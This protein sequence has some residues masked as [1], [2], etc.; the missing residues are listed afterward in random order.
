MQKPKY[1]YMGG[2]LRPWEEATLHVA[3]E[4]A[5]RSA[6][7]FEGIKG[8]WQP[9]GSFS[10]VMLRQHYDRLRRSARILRMPFDMSFE[11]YQ[12]AI[13]E[14]VAAL[15]EPKREM[16]ARTTLFAIEG[17][18]GEGTVTDLVI[19]AYH[20]SSE[21]P[22]PI[23]L[24]IS[25]WRRSNDVSLPA[26]V[27]AGTNY[28][29]GRLARTEGRPQGYQ[30]MV[31]LNEAGRVSEATGACLVMVRD[32]ALHTPP[33]TEG[34]LE[35]ITL[36]IIEQLAKAMKIPFAR[37]PIDR[38]EL[39]VA[40]EIALCGTLADVTLVKS[41]EGLALVEG[42]PVLTRLQSAYMKAVRGI[43][44]QSFVELTPL[45]SFGAKKRA[46]AHA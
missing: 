40:D 43:A 30:D 45:P 37:R 41:I 15:I 13:D 23:N 18:W 34:T 22:A 2:G 29:V 12:A 14:L 19:T 6:S 32:G 10:I 39:L 4:A 28:Q 38:T 46:S 3:C 11:Q 35:S 31:L 36:D 17:N 33:T 26:R 5:I 20:H 16:W 44:P 1:V 9:D 27:K 25:T 7:V 8:F 21:P 24:G 42:S